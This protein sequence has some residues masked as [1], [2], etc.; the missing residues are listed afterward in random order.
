[1][2]SGG[3]FLMV[4]FTSFGEDPNYSLPS[5]EL[6]WRTG[7]SPFLVGKSTISTGSFSIAMVN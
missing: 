5:G 2:K 4:D 1:M 6:T 7:K 3:F